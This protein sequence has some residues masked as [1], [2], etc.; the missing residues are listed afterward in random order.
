LNGVNGNA[1]NNQN[2]NANVNNNAANIIIA[3][4]GKK[5]KRRSTT[6]QDFVNKSNCLTMELHSE[7]GNFP[8]AVF[9][10]IKVSKI[11]IT[12]GSALQIST[13]HVF[14]KKISKKNFKFFF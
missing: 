9:Q 4:P 7:L 5:R 11:C 12:R 10:S 1:N 14:K 2:N 8:F 13:N 3:M 6:A